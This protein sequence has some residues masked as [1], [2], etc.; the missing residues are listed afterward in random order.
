MTATD[1][2]EIRRIVRL[3]ALRSAVFSL[4]SESLDEQTPCFTVEVHLD[5]LEFSASFAFRD[6]SGNLI[7][8]GSL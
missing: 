2:D 5:D 3:E 4:A 6:S 1:V 8:G 7:A